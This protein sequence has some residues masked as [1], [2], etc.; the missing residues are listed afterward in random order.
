MNILKIVYNRLI[1]ATMYLLPFI[2]RNQDHDF[3]LISDTVKEYFPTGKST[4]LTPETVVSSPGYEK[5][6]KICQEEFLDKKAYRDKWG[7]LTSHLKKVFK[8]SVRGYPDLASGGFFGEVIIEEDKSPDFIREKSLHFYVSTIG[9]FFSI[10]AVDSSIALLEIDFHMV[11][12]RKGNFEA[13]HAITLSPV[14]EY[15]EVFLKLESELRAFFLGYLFVPYQIGMSTIKNISV[16]D[17]LRDPRALDTVYEALFGYGAVRDCLTRGDGYYGMNDWIKSLN[18]KEKSLVDVVS[19]N[20]AAA[21]TDITIH[22]VWKLQE[23]KRL[24]TFGISGN[25]M[26]GMNLFDIIDLSDKSTVIMTSSK[27]GTPGSTKYKIEDNV[28]KIA[29]NYSLRIVSLSQDTLTLNLI[30]DFDSDDVSLKG[31][32]LEM[33]FCQMKDSALQGV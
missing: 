4:R 25:L 27:S 17:E 31:E 11:E 3:T 15:R 18:K 26:F 2:K 10:Y 7:K 23:S 6:G 20:I 33:R 29:S 30:L 14:F 13:I 28:I 9:P 22:K 16:A 12:Y 8:T 32:V 1:K 5:I 19:K 21:P 24:D